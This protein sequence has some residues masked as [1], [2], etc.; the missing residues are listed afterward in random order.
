M[1]SEL[2]WM[3][4]SGVELARY[5]LVKKCAEQR[6]ID[7][8]N[9]FWAGGT[10]PCSNDNPQLEAYGHGDGY[11]FTDFPLGN[12]K[13]SVKITDMERKFD[14]NLLANPRGPQLDDF[15]KG[16]DGSGRDGPVAIL[17]D[18]GFDPGLGQPRPAIPMSTA[19]KT[20][21]TTS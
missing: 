14:I 12:G 11:A 15:A 21:T 2:E 19:P 18:H 7:S 10:S 1:T 8:L 4:R 20:S 16:P 5:A 3:G 6:D 17:Q 9:Q 13:I